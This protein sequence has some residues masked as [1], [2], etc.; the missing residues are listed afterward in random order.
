MEEKTRRRWR[1]GVNR[2]IILAL[3]LLAV[4]VVA[5]FP[6]ISP[7]IL[8]APERISETPLV[9]L[10]VIGPFY[11]TNTLTTLVL[12]DLIVIITALIVRIST[13][14]EN[15]IPTGFTGAVEAL[16]EAMYN[17]TESTAGRW[18]KFIFPWFA[19]FI[20]VVLVSNLIALIPGME[21]IGSLVA[22]HGEDG[23]NA[24]QILPGVAAMVPG[25]EGHAGAYH[26]IPWFRGM[27]TDLNF[28]VAL[29][30]VSVIATQV[31]GFQAQGAGY[32]SRFL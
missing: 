32:I 28:T 11:L 15:M 17:L 27:S 5:Y 4:L 19:T 3:T 9:T 26:I 30:L 31:I 6:P 22:A 23:H 16:V 14:R 24:F 13:R 20:I 8:V 1:F 29:A 10:P 12:V 18:T 25:A 21:S 2:W 7:I